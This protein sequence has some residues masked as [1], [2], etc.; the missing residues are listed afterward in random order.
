LFQDGERLGRSW[1]DVYPSDEFLQGLTPPR[2]IIAAREGSRAMVFSARQKR[3]I[4]KDIMLAFEASLDRIDAYERLPS[5]WEEDS[6]VRA[7]ALMACGS[8]MGAA[9][10]VRQLLETSRAKVDAGPEMSRPR[11][12]FTLTTREFRAGLANLR[13]LD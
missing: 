7:L 9:F 10:E 4:K 1:T 2:T 12:V 3:E 6:L 5:R 8:L 11:P 13:A